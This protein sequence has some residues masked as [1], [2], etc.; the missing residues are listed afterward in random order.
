MGI[1]EVLWI[2]RI[3]GDLEILY[4]EPIKVHC[5]N[6]M[7][8]SMAH[9]PIYHGKTKHVDVDQFYIKDYLDNKIV[10]TSYVTIVDLLTK[11]LRSKTF[12]K[13]LSKLGMRSIHSFTLGGVMK[14]GLFKYLPQFKKKTL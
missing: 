6:K 12:I 11:R 9:D 4:E 10:C 8:I 7:A 3:F 14:R 13:L 2:R 1:A 5:D